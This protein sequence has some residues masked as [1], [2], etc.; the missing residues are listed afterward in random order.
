V[1]E[2]EL[3]R[4]IDGATQP[5]PADFDAFVLAMWL[6]FVRAPSKSEIDADGS[7]DLL[8]IGAARE[9][10]WTRLTPYSLAPN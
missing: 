8:E 4:T 5:R 1:I 2:G 7:F 10:E 9:K 6:L 3:E